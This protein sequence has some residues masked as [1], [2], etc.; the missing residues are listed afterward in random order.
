MVAE[1]RYEAF[2]L[3]L[4]K[5]IL[6]LWLGWDPWHRVSEGAGEGAVQAERHPVVDW[7]D[8]TSSQ[9]QLQIKSLV[10]RNA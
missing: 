3:L 5:T 9:T 7:R 6:Q 1:K 10:V 8:Q 2:P 4:H